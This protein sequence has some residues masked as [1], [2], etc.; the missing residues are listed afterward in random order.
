MDDPLASPPAL[1]P[2]AAMPPGPP[3]SS[4]TQ[5]DLE[6]AKRAE[7]A[8]IAALVRYMLHDRG[9]PAKD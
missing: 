2:T 9:E 6:R 8:R 1:Q 4:A 7:A 3:E 5:R